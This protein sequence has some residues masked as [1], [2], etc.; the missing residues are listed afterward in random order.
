MLKLDFV[1][2]VI[3]NVQKTITVLNLKVQISMLDIPK[4]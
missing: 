2:I 4:H 3:K 1:T